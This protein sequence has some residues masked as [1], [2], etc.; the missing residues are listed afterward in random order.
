MQ[1]AMYTQETSHW[2]ALM[3]RA[4]AA[5][6]FYVQPDIENYLVYM[7]TC[8]SNDFDF[9]PYRTTLYGHEAMSTTKKQSRLQDVRLIGEQSLVVSGLFPDHARRTG[10]PLLYLMDK[11]RNAYRELANAFPGNF[12]YAYVCRYFIN[13]VDV[14]QQLAEICGD[15]HSMDL[16][17][18]CELWQVTG[19]RHS[20]NVIMNHTRAFPTATASELRH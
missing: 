13:I 7:L 5:S 4:Q 14:L 20:W 1:L 11:G 8:L 2:Y 15:K 3:N 12:I 18:A 10:I 17:Q 19:S 16:I 6:D 9:V